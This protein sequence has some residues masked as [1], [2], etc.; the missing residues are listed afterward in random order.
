MASL[1]MNIICGKQT[2]YIPFKPQQTGVKSSVLLP[3]GL[4]IL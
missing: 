4:L 1:G 3:L 2:G